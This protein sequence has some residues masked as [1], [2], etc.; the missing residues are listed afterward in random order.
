MP[1]KYLQKN[2]ENL[3]LGKGFEKFYSYSKSKNL[4]EATLKYYEENFNRFEKTVSELLE[5]ADDEEIFVEYITPQ[6]IEQYRLNL[7]NRDIS[8]K[9]VNSYLRGIR[10]IK[11]QEFFINCQKSYSVLTILS[12]KFM[13]D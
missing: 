1:T 8:N 7:L 4:S 10:L 3:T 5:F 2:G 9:T 11:S 6:I 13:T 12:H